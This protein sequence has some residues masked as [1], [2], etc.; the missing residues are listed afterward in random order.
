MRANKLATCVRQQQIVATVLAMVAE[1]G[2]A[3][4]S[5][6]KVAGRL[7]LA[8]SALYRH[9]R[10]KNAMLDAAVERHAAQVHAAFADVCAQGGSA[11]K[12]LRQLL[13]TQAD[14]TAALRVA[15]CLPL[16]QGRAAASLQRQLDDIGR[17]YIAGIG[18]L[19]EEGRRRGEITTPLGVRPLSIVFLGLLQSVE[20]FR[21]LYHGR[22]AGR[23]QALHAWRGYHALLQQP[24]KKKSET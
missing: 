13:L 14:G 18:R 11:C 8:P 3:A 17:T 9:F 2:A 19:I 20:V 5:V 24:S 10:D 1:N 16:S 6:A 7:G 15:L 21:Q 23:S 22:G 12:R 4:L